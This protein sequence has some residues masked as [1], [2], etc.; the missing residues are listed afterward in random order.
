MVIERPFFSIIIPT[1]NRAHFLHVAIESVL[2]QTFNDFELII[3]DDGSTDNTKDLVKTYSKKDL[4]IIYIYQKNSERSAARNNGIRNAKGQYICFLDSDDYYL[5]TRLGGIHEFIIN[6]TIKKGLFY[7][8]NLFKTNDDIVERKELLNNF[9]SIFDFIALAV[10][11]NPQVC[12]SSDIFSK[13][14]FNE[15]IN[16]GED[17]ELWLRIAEDFPIVFIPDQATVIAVN[18]DDRSVN[19]SK[20]NSAEKQLKSFQICFESGHPGKNINPKI[21]KALIGNCYFNICKYYIYSHYR[22]KAISAIFISVL[23]DLKS[24]QLIFRLN[25][26]KK[27]ILFTSLEKLKTF[28]N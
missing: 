25:I 22:F 23:K 14:L 8:S 18:H 9:N 28:V 20:F 21:K 6:Q 13:H 11:G 7:T 2:N 10:I 17:M 3:V 15:K 24:P 27:L 4:R 19:L 26:L 1:F 12:I 16:I 5:P